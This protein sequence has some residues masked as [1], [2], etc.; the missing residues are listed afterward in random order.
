MGAR[1]AMSDRI[2]SELD[3]YYGLCFEHLC[4]QALPVIY[5]RE[6]VNAAFE[7]GEYWDKNVQ[8]DV[9][10]LRDEAGWRHPEGPCT[11][12]FHSNGD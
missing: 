6:G 9:V 1:R 10:G 12:E 2:R 8:I 5:D 3:A 11:P 7:V 4:R